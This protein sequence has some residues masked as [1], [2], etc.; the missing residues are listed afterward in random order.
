MIRAT[1][2]NQYGIDFTASE[3][4]FPLPNGTCD[5]LTDYIMYCLKTGCIL[6]K[7]E[8]EPAI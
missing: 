4:E 1:F 7:L 8:R 3:D 5:S 6:I 2:I